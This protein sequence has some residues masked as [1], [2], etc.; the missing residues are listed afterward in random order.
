L[1]GIEKKPFNN[2][3]GLASL[4]TCMVSACWQGFY[5]VYYIFFFLF[6]LMEQSCTFLEEDYDF[7]KKMEKRI[8]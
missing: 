4:I 2:N 7:F 1:I 5:P 8:L 3:R 6:F